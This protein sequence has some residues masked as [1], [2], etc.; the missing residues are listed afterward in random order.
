MK[1]HDVSN[2]QYKLT[3]GLFNILSHLLYRFHTHGKENIKGL[4]GPDNPVVIIANHHASTEGVFVGVRIPGKIRF[5]GKRK[6]VWRHKLV[7]M[8]HDVFGTIPVG[9]ENGVKFPSVDLAVQS[10][11]E[12]Y[13]IGLF[14]EGAIKPEEKTW[15]GRTGAAR[16]ALKAKV[17]IVPVGFQGTMGILKE[18]NPVPRKFGKRIDLIFG[19]PIYLD[20]FYGMENDQNALRFIMDVAMFEVRR[21]SNW[22]GVPEDVKQRLIRYYKRKLFYSK[23]AL[24]V[25]ERMK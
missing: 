16:I 12:G 11:K 13:S 23:E 24:V 1:L 9:E 25:Y 17:P 10:I 7:A 6:T 20:D 15:E 8:F 22:Y 18:G 5:L 3:K 14:P 19:K 4:G 2:A 21:L